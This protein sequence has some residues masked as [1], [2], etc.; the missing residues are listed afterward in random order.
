MLLKDYSLKGTY[1]YSGSPDTS[2]SN[3]ARSIL[4][5][6][7]KIKVKEI[8]TSEYN[9]KVK[10]PLNSRLDCSVLE[11]NFGIKRPLWN[12]DLKIVL[13]ELENN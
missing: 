11:R 2:W 3:F 5:N 10:R 4:E 6:N 9:S 8:K 1:H 13:S 12:D 7:D